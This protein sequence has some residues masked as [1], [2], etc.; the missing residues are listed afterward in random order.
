MEA[1][2]SIRVS[3]PA[4]RLR[5]LELGRASRPTSHFTDE[6]MEAQFNPLKFQLEDQGDVSWTCRQSGG[7]VSASRGPAQA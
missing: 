3:P 6:E 1:K 7:E 2:K 4:G 5:M